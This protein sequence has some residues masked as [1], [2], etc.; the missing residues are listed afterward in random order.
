MK[1]TKNSAIFKKKRPIVRSIE[2]IVRINVSLN[3]S[4]LSCAW[5][6]SATKSK[7]VLTITKKTAMFLHSFSCAK[8]QDLIEDTL[9]RRYVSMGKEFKTQA[10][11]LSYGKVIIEYS[12][13]HYFLANN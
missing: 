8:N 11:K 10:G 3:P 6:G 9:L 4:Q 7:P 5:A 12:I 13:P 1:L 2:E